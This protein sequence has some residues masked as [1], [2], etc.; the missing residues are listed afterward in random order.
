MKL[1]EWIEK[2][3][4]LYVDN[5]GLAPN[6]KACY[7]RAAAAM[8]PTL[9]AVDMANLSALDVLPWIQ[10][11]AATH[12]RAAQLD[13]IML[14]KALRIA[15]KLGLCRP[16]IMDPELVPKPVYEPPEALILNLDQLRAYMAKAASTEI[17]P[18]L[19]LCCCGLR[20]GESL[21]AR[22]DDF[23]PFEGILTIRGQRRGDLVVP[24]KSRHSLRKLRLPL[25]VVDVL[26]RWPRSLSG[27]ICDTTQQRM[28]I[29]HNRLL[30]DLELPH[31]TLHGLRHSFAT[32]AVCDR[33]VPVK[34]L[35]GALGHGHYALTADLYADHLPPVSDVVSRVFC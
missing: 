6:T 22:W 23:D 13:R 30:R 33:S 5:T 2:W 16:G 26:R 3:L 25:Q 21:G 1:G 17:A 35:Q 15:S 24:L 4:V 31:V 9:L 19:L 28:Y 12:P 18:V 11:V 14:S 27:W 8:P 29:V 7:H 34:L 32:A 10:L 20:R